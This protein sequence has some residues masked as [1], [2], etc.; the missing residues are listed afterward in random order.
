MPRRAPGVVSP[1]L[2]RKNTVPLLPPP[3]PETE[4]GQDADTRGHGQ[5]G[6]G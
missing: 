2:S 5:R 4:T 1:R 6:Q 3:V